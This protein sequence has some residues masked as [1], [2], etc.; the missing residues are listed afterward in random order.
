MLTNGL[1]YLC[2]NSENRIQGQER[3]LKDHADFFAANF[4][5]LH[6]GQF[7]QIGVLEAYIAGNLR[8]PGMIKKAQ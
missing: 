8:F 4:V 3:L 5:S 6:L 2:S 1:R 7:G